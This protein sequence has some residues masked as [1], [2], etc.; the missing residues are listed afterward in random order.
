MR[1]LAMEIFCSISIY[2]LGMPEICHAKKPI[3]KSLDSLTNH[4]IKESRPSSFSTLH[5]QNKDSSV[6]KRP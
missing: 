1:T 6:L 4:Q 5:L 2:E 3:V